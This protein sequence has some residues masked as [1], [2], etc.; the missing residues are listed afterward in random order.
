MIDGNGEE[1]WEIPNENLHILKNEFGQLN[2][3]L[4]K[5]HHRFQTHF[6]TYTSTENTPNFE[7]KSVEKTIREI[8]IKVAIFEFAQ[9]FLGIQ[10]FTSIWKISCENDKTLDSLSE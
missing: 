7:E 4:N 1:K 8:F 3:T 6:L 10:H 5:C 2:F 9:T